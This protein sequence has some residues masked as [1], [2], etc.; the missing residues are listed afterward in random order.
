MKKII[1]IWH[2]PTWYPH[3]HN[4]SLG[5]FVKKQIQAAA[6]FSQQVVFFVFEDSNLQQDY[7]LNITEKGAIREV[8]VAISPSKSKLGA[9]RKKK[10]AFQL[11]IKTV[12]EQN[13]KP[14]FIHAHSISFA[15]FVAKKMANKFQ[16]KWFLSEH[17]S[18]YLSSAKGFDNMPSYKKKIWTFHANQADGIICVSDVLK[19]AM[20]QC[21]ITNQNFI[22][23]P[24]VV[25]G[26]FELSFDD[27]GEKTQTA[28]S[29]FVFLNVSDM[30]DEIKNISGLIQAFNQ[31]WLNNK[32]IKLLLVGDGQD[33]DKLKKLAAELPACD[34]V[35][36]LG[37]LNPEEVLQIY[38]KIDVTIINSRYE[39]FS[40]VA[41]E[42]VYAGKPIIT[43]KCGGPEEFITEKQGI[44]ISIDD[45]VALQEAM[46][47]MVLIASKY[48]SFEL[49]SYIK[50]QFS[51][52]K[53]ADKLQELYQ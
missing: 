18:G 50:N 42:S 30:V 1:N 16:V 17:W 49:H 44:L 43:S 41:A 39:T 34:A 35:K 40:V 33:L 20:I 38:S 12:L 9:L 45:D 3:R 27:H 36:F 14:D 10:K 6:K 24:N 2:F 29:D 51:A 32:R 23:I 4:W 28:S 19:K 8:F 13:N 46:K 22:I 15:S 25:E 7:Q 52:Q 47:S 26:E 5:S 48:D 21:G 37:R 53:I 31:I 11:A